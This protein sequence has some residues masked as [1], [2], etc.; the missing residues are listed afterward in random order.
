MVKSLNTL[1]LGLLAAPNIYANAQPFRKRKAGSLKSTLKP[2]MLF[3]VK[4]TTKPATKHFVKFTIEATATLAP[5]PTLKPALKPAP[6]LAIRK[7]TQ[8]PFIQRRFQFKNKANI[9]IKAPKN[10][11][12][13]EEEVKN[14]YM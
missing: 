9:S 4:P 14:I 11:N 1:I 12:I 10:L 13:K 8:I 6:K 5:K 7:L 3:N 2:V